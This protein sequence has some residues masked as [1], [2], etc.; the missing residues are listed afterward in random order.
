MTGWNLQFRDKGKNNR[1]ALSGAQLMFLQML[2]STDFVALMIKI[3]SSTFIIAWLFDV[4]A[5]IY[6]N[7]LVASPILGLRPATCC[8]SALLITHQWRFFL[9]FS[10]LRLTLISRNAK[11]K[12]TVIILLS[13]ASRPLDSPF[14]EAPR[15]VPSWR[16][17]NETPATPKNY[18]PN[19]T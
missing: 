3:V 17:M 4:L 2:K 18:S 11:R 13:E 8:E 16:R 10:S 15:S 7:T 19:R 5:E 1:P 14:Y 12:S 6:Y 9:D